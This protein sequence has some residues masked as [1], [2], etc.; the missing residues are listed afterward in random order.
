MDFLLIQNLPPFR[1][2]L[3]KHTSVVFGNI[4]F[5]EYCPGFACSSSI[6]GTSKMWTPPST[7]LSL[8]PCYT[9]NKD[10]TYRLSEKADYC[11]FLL[12]CWLSSISCSYTSC[13]FYF[14]KVNAGKQWNVLQNVLI[15]FH[16]LDF[17]TTHLNVKRV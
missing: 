3:S 6:V 1:N 4:S 11:R 5:C 8:I 9:H 13:Y 17:V 14:N 12:V 7:N 16:W 2:S 10:Y 15:K